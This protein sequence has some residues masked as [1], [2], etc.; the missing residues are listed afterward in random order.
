[1]SLGRQVGTVRSNQG[2]VEGL[3]FFTTEKFA[4]STCQTYIR[5]TSVS[6]VLNGDLRR[7]IGQALQVTKTGSFYFA[8]TFV[9]LEPRNSEL[10][11]VE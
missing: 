9:S 2:I 8:G 4:E 5:I 3:E 1:M 10:Y 11:Q 6:A 7:S